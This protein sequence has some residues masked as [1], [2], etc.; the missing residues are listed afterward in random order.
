MLFSLLALDR[1]TKNSP[2]RVL[3]HRLVLMEVGCPV[4]KDRK[5]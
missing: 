5:I 4:F 2:L 1:G 3:G